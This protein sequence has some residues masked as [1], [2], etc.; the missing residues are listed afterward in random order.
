MRQT[1]R[2]TNVAP[3]L[4]LIP[5]MQQVSK[6]TIEISALCRQDHEAAQRYSRPFLHLIIK[7]EF[8]ASLLYFYVIILL[9]TQL[10]PVYL[11]ITARFGGSRHAPMNSTTFSCLI[12]LSTDTSLRNSSTSSFVDLRR[13]WIIIS[14]CHLPLKKRPG[15]T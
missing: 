2:G 10:R 14:P 7:R 1:S 6:R 15:I 11:V 13:V 5:S 12:I 4:L 3:D 8:W 9:V